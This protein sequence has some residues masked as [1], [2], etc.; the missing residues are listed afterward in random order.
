M[1][2]RTPQ[3][4]LAANVGRNND[5]MGR[6]FNWRYLRILILLLIAI[7]MFTWKGRNRYSNE[8]I[9]SKVT[10]EFSRKKFLYDEFLQEV[11]KKRLD[12]ANVGIAY[13]SK[14]N[15]IFVDY[16]NDSTLYLNSENSEFKE[17]VFLSSAVNSWF[18]LYKDTLCQ[19]QTEYRT[20]K[21][22]HI[23]LMKTINDKH[24]LINKYK[25][26]ITLNSLTIENRLSEWRYPIDDDWSIIAG[27][28][29]PEENIYIILFARS[30]FT[31][32]AFAFFFII[33]YKVLKLLRPTAAKPNQGLTCRYESFS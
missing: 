20:K 2:L 27:E 28:A 31:L 17:L 21:Y 9:I 33:E 15:S 26:Y 5:I 10:K 32:L 1:L 18:R 7:F 12:T 4:F 8:I 24:V 25:N 13:H 29:L 23:Y 22:A 30:I 16:Y 19:F 6:L 3:R 11:R 14:G